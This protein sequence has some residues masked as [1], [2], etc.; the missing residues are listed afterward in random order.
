MTDCA[1]CGWRSDDG[2]AVCDECKFFVNS[3]PVLVH[4]D[5][6]FIGDIAGPQ[7]GHLRT[8][9]I[10]HVVSLFPFVYWRAPDVE[11]LSLDLLD[12]PYARIDDALRMAITFIDGARARNGRVLVHCYAGISRS[13]TMVIGYLME[14]Q[15]MSFDEALAHVRR[16]WPR[17]SPNTG[18]ANQLEQ[19]QRSNPPI[20]TK[21]QD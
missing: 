13:S 15:G 3:K 14:K 19:I 9:Q 4:E 11:F 2:A 20:K 18:F 21:S 10:T 12:T 1:A 17:A 16:A 7:P 8:H 6:L 5:W